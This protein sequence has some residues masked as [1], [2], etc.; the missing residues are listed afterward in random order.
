MEKYFLSVAPHPL[1]MVCWWLLM[2][3]LNNFDL[4]VDWLTVAILTNIVGWPLLFGK[5]ERA[6]PP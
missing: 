6:S 3:V 5:L 4:F 2:C 1:L